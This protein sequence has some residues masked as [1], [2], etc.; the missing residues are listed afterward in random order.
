MHCIK[1]PLE[2]CMLTKKCTWVPVWLLTLKHCLTNCKCSKTMAL[3]GKVVSS[4]LTALI[5]F[6]LNTARWIKTVMLHVLVLLEQQVVALVLPMVK[7][8]TVMVF[9]LQI[10]TGKKRWQNTLAK[11]KLI[12]INTKTACFPCV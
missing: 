8:Q 2:F 10:L 7:K 12:L 9:V 5:L 4:F 11:T 6:F 1:F 3:T